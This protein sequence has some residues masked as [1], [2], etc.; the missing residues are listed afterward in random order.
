[1]N[2]QIQF[3][4][5][6]PHMFIATRTFAL[7][8]SGVSVPEGSEIGFDG[9]MVHYAGMQISMPQ[10]RGALRIGW[11]VPRDDYDPNDHSASIPQPAGVTLRHSTQGGNPLDPAVRQRQV[12][13]VTTD[14]NERQVGNVREMADAAKDRNQTRSY[15]VGAENRAVMSG[16]VQVEDQ[17]GVPV[18]SLKTKAKNQTTLTGETAGSALREANSSGQIQPGK[19]I[20]EAEMLARMTAV[21]RAEYMASKEAKKSQYVDVASSRQVVGSVQAPE[22]KQT[23][24]FSVT[25]SV[26]RG[27]ETFDGGGTGVAGKAQE[28]VIESEGMVFKNVNGPKKGVQMVEEPSPPEPKGV[29]G[30]EDA[31][32]KIA[33]ALC[34]DF[35][36]LYDFSDPIRKKI[37]RIQADFDDRPD[38]IQAIFAAETDDM[39]QKLMQEFPDCF[40]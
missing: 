16:T 35:P 28:T 34:P 30:T 27:V 24:G 20:T 32:R 18:R 3:V 10:L 29:N 9:T 8:A 13:P 19:G 39:K 4:T 25:G 36:D 12:A 40:A 15:R 11:L 1:M 21:E 33:K 26:G 14:E 5:G 6:Q 38:I 31:R 37:A 17:D 22:T 23:E 7:G 2:T